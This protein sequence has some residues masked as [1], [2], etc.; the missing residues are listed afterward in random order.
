MEKPVY[1]DKV[2]RNPDTVL[3]VG[4]F[5]G[6]H[7]G[8]R[9]LIRNVV[10]SAHTAGRRSVVVTFDPHPREILQPGALGIR[11]LTT[12]DERAEVLAE[13]GVDEMVVIPFTRDFSLLS[14]EQFIRDV[15]WARI[16]MAHVITGYDHHFGR[17]REGGIDTLRTLG[18]DL[19]FT[20]ELVGKHDVG[21][22]TVSSTV[23]RRA[24]EE[25]GDVD[26]V[27]RYL[28]RPYRL[29][30]IV[31]HGHKRGR[32]I[33]FPTANLRLQDPRKMVPATGVYAVRVDAMGVVWKGMMN[34]GYRPTY[35]SGDTERHIEVHLIG[36]QGDLYGQLLHLDVMRRIRDEMRF[37]DA[38]ALREQLEQ[39]RVTC[40]SV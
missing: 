25:V 17:N 9:A 35:A 26:R 34:I 5:D 37:P 33:G 22:E 15:L 31:V 4:T 23:V 2:I 24:L 38:S 8:H 21:E 29:T 10:E 1:L 39:D 40:E 7:Q 32:I 3:T 28:G 11:L 20:V 13:L 36:F 30:G 12:L 14:S 19:G 18:A 27:T 16:G 6:V